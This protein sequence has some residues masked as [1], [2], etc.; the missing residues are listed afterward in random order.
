[1]PELHSSAVQDALAAL[2]PLLDRHREVAS[3]M[4]SV[5]DGHLY[6]LDIL[7]MAAVNR[8]MAH[9]A[10]FRQMVEA[11]NFICAA[12][13][14]RLQL[15]TALRFA[16]AWLAPDPHALA[17][18][19]LKGTSIRAQKDRTGHRMT[20]AYLVSVLAKDDPWIPNVYKQT[21]GYI[22]LSEKHIF[23]SVTKVGDDGAFEMKMS[24][25]DV[26][27][28]DDLYIESVRAFQAASEVFLR[29]LEGWVFT[30]ANPGRSRKD[31][32]SS[33]ADA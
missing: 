1:V 19:V 3:A 13:I 32:A 31:G 11:W 7:A 12:S 20:D 28:T 10:G 24:P 14:L 18:E 16:A 29:Y 4:L 15:D 2:T 17:H 21:S 8:S 25:D 26:V 9:I 30:K 6:S 33:A 5:D 23:N 27:I 22:H